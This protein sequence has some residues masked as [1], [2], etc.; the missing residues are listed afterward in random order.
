MAEEGQPVAD[1]EPC[2]GCQAAPGTA[3]DEDCTHAQCPDCGEQLYM[4]ECE[5]DPNGN[6][7][8]RPALWHGLDQ[9]AR[10]AR[11]LGWWTAVVG[12][13]HLVEDYSRVVVAVAL[14]QVVWDRQAQAYVIGHIDKR[15]LDRVLGCSS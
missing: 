11:E 10:V 14:G 3:H 15:E 7:P 2:C 8:G 1:A 4:H 6:G 12:I 13:D 5:L 9:R